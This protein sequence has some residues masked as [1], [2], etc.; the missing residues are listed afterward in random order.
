MDAFPDS[1][2]YGG[3]TNVE[4]LEFALNYGLSSSTRI[5]VDFYSMDVISGDSDQE[6]LVQIDLLVKI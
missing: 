6:T 4:G 5:G 2:A 1:D 3:A